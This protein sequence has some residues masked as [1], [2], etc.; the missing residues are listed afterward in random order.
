MEVGVKV[1]AGIRKDA[2]PRAV[3]IDA[4][5]GWERGLAIGRLACIWAESQSLKITHASGAIIASWGHI[6]D[7]SASKFFDVACAT[8]VHFFERLDDGSYRIVGGA[9]EIARVEDYVAKKRA[10]GRRGAAA[11]WNGKNG[12]QHGKRM[13]KEKMADAMANGWPSLNTCDENVAQNLDTREPR[14]P[15]PGASVWGAYAGAYFARYGVAPIRDV[16]ANSVCANLVKRLGLDAAISVARFYVNH[17]DS[18]YVRK[19]HDIGLC[20]SD[21]PGLHTQMVNGQTVTAATAAVK[22]RQ[23]SNLEAARGAMEILE[24]RKK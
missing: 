23:Q 17:N 4:E 10:A 13:A 8:K 5:M 16:K 18:F 3:L 9:K 22:D 14:T 2:F 24:G 20:L 11:R 12:K 6:P 1:Y 19:S 15:T 21:A 7:D